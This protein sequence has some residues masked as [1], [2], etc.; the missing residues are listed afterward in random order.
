M[1]PST[2][3]TRRRTV[4]TSVCRSLLAVVPVLIVGCGG[5]DPESTLPPRPVAWVV[6]GS[7]DGAV[8]RSFSGSASTDRV[9]TLSFRSAGVLTGLD[10]RLGDRVRE[11]QTLAELDNVAAR[12][13][14]EQARSQLNSAESQMNTARLALDRTR[15]LYESGNAALSDYENARNAFRTAEAGHASAQRSVQIQ[16]E[17]ISYGRIIAPASGIIASVGVEE[18]EN[19]NPGQPVAVLNAGGT[20]QIALGLPETVI[21]R[22]TQ[23]MEVGVAFAALP[24]DEFRGRV[25]E[26]SPSVD[27]TTATYP[28]RVAVVDATDQIRTGM[29]ATV[30]FEFA[31]TPGAAGALVVPARAVGEDGEGRFVFVIEAGTGDVGVVRRRSVQV[32]RLGAEGF[33]IVSGLERGERVAVAGLQTLLDGQQVSGR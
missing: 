5:G 13:G 31:A 19:V 30:T 32:G 24:A 10:I 9:L 20:M 4:A 22:V 15:S 27:R 3:I 18:G 28:V 21:N 33:E 14:Y 12:L 25:T 2:P 23:G 16:E 17:Q 29:A 26:V 1:T 8:T 6:V 11:G 7:G